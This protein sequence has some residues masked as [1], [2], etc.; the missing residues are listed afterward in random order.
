MPDDDLGE[1][2]T[3]E[4]KRFVF[5]GN[6]IFCLHGVGGLD[7]D[8]FSAPGRDEVD[9][10]WCLHGIAG[11]VPFERVDD[12]DIHGTPADDQLVIDDVLHDMRQLLL[13]EADTGV[14]QADVLAVV[15]VGATEFYHTSLSSI[16]IIPLDCFRLPFQVMHV[17]ML[18]QVTLAQHFLFLFQLLHPNFRKKHNHLEMI[19][20]PLPH[21]MR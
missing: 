11:L 7:V 15:L 10:P 19:V 6:L 8:F 2:V 18:Q 16:T 1:G 4:G 17:L 21:E 5:G 20:V 3:G 14:A 12:S 9:L 13:A